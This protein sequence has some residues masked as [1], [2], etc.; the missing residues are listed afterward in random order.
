MGSKQVTLTVTV[1][2]AAGAPI[3]GLTASAFTAQVKSGYNIFSNG[4]FAVTPFS[5]FA[6]HADGTY[7]VVFTGGSNYSYYSFNSLTAAGVTIETGSTGVTTPAGV[8]PVLQSAAVGV[9]GAVVTMTFD[10]EM[11]SP[12]SGDQE[13]FTAKVNGQDRTFSAI[14]LNSDG[15]NT[16]FDLTLNGSPVIAGDTVTL[17]YNHNLIESTD[18]GMLQTIAGYTVTN[19]ST[20]A[21]SLTVSSAAAGTATGT[22]VVTVAETAGAGDTFVYK[23]GSAEVTGLKVSDTLTDGTAFTSALTEISVTADQYVTIYEINGTS[24]VVKY[25]SRKIVSGEFKPA[26]SD[27]GLTT[28]LSSPIT[29]TGTGTSDS[30]KTASVSVAS[31]VATAGRA[32][33]TAAASA[34][35]NLYSDS[36]FLTEITD[37]NTIDL[38]SGAGTD[39]YVKVTAEDGTACYYKVTVNRAAIQ[40]GTPAT[41]AWDTTTPGKA[42][43]DAVPNASSYTVSLFKDAGATAVDT[44]STT[45][46]S[47]DFTDA[48]A[49]NGTGNYTFTVMAMGDQVYYTNSAFSAK[50]SNYI[51]A[52]S[53]AGLATVLSQSIS[54]TGTGTSDS[55]KTASIDAAYSADT[56]AKANI[57]ATDSNATVYF[58]GTDITF[59]TEDNDGVALTAGTPITVYIKI[60][61]QDTTTSLYYAVT[62]TRAKPVISIGTQPDGAVTVTA[63]SISE[64][65][66]AAATVTEGSVNYQWYSAEDTGK[67]NPQKIDG[68]TDAS[69]SIPTEL[70]AGTY[71]YFCR[72]SATDADDV[73]TNVATVTVEGTDS[74]MPTVGNSGVITTNS[75]MS[76]SLTLNWTKAADNKTSEANLKYYVYQSGSDN[77]GTPEDCVANGTLLNVGGTADVNTYNVTSLTPSSTY[78]FNVMVED[79]AGNK[80]AYVMVSATTLAA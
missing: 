8:P 70:T 34:T 63:G 56:L 15:T 41:L 16:K 2:D 11:F 51:Y 39:I 6:D 61:A 23:V 22:T 24:N 69:F 49:L 65:L 59:G 53:D 3:T 4:S 29:A 72:V 17:T 1:K 30:P 31:G 60:T 5:S 47:Y 45:S 9:D 37:A 76:E 44:Q 75:V 26:S 12:R 55:P 18:F 68:K 28:V 71:Y 13:L 43:W 79:E 66:S 77:I 62:I 10:K 54:A 40:L 48:I 64:S 33:I 73:D 27:A 80:A 42:T 32:D 21:G 52:S 35:F 50:S 46:N 20:M 7:T 67:T 38:A 19:N 78:Y 36:G 58:Y 14:T 25:V 57:A 74:T